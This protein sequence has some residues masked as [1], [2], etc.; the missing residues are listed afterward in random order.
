M[1]GIV[2]CVNGPRARRPRRESYEAH[3]QTNAKQMIKLA[4]QMR[5]AELRWRSVF[6]N[7]HDTVSV[8][9]PTG[10]VVEANQRWQ[11]VLGIAPSDM[12]GRHIREFSVPELA[13]HNVELFGELRTHGSQRVVVALAHANGSVVHMEFAA[14]VVDVEG[15]PYVIAIG[16]D[17]TEKLAAEQ[18]AAA[19][20]L[21]RRQLEERLAHGQRLE[22]IGQLTGSIAH[23]FNNILS[24][25]LANAEMLVD[26]LPEGTACEGAADIR[27]AALRA[28]ALTRQLLAFGRRQVLELVELDVG[29]V[30]RQVAR[31]IQRLVG[32]GIALSIQEHGA[33]LVRAD[34]VQLEQVIMNLAVNA[35]DAMP[36]GGKLVIESAEVHVGDG[37][38]VRAGD[39]VV[40]SVS[41]TGCGMSAETQHRIFEPFF[42]TKDRSHGT[43]L[44]LSTCFGIVKQLGGEIVVASELGRGTTMKVYLPRISAVSNV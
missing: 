24:V 23:D 44:G 38:E 31:M 27:D 35:R 39:Y 37:G 13:D 40:V 43:G 29:E 41:D 3:L 18:R 21:E 36:D 34:V 9:T 6:E 15:A 19:A 26:E 33:T 22:M 12:I 2:A 4:E 8:L 7:A 20:E 42:T 28:T 10:T 16:R 32:A 25:V 1:A 14:R 17:M 5:S 11:D 30:V